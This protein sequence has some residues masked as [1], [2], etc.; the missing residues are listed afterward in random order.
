MREAFI[1]AYSVSRAA[2]RARGYGHPDALA[3]IEEVQAEYVVRYGGRDTTPLDPAMF[4]PPGGSF[5][6]GY[7]L[8]GRR[9]RGHRRVARPLRRRSARHPPYGG[10]QAD[11]RRP[12]ARGAGHARAMLAHLEATAAE[13][14]AEV[15]ILE[16]G[17]A[18]PE[19]MALYES[20]G[21]TR[22]PSFGH[23]KDEPLNRCY[24]RVL[25]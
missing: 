19:A 15:M 22:S 13:A 18:Q 20:S 14:G 17:T 24:G 9:P 6:V 5:F 1:A 2:H 8:T 10:G 23:Y 3:L 16:T 4:E 21:Y 25:A 11:V 12:V 7:R